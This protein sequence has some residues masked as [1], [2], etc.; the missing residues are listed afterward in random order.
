MRV[1]LIGLPGSGKS[2][3]GRELATRLTVPFVD[4]D[5]AIEK[6]TGKKISNIFQEQGEDAFRKLEHDQLIKSIADESDF[7][8]A[9]GG[10]APCYHNNMDII[11][12]A[13]TSIFLDVS[14]KHLAKR[15]RQMEAG[16][17][18]LLATEAGMTL[19]ERL[20]Q[21]R[22]QRLHFYQEATH[23]ITSDAISIADVLPLISRKA[24]QR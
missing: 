18:P 9:T 15:L 11:N 22:S 7:V 8:M 10:G 19:I 3:L 1:F 12:R 13:G 14:V 5:Q 24:N 23:C 17:R 4:L 2:T 6:N 20:E 16:S 21:L